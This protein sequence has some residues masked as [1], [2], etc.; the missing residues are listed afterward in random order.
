MLPRRRVSENADIF[1]YFTPPNGKDENQIHMDH[2][3]K[4][5]T[6]QET[7]QLSKYC[8]FDNHS[9]TIEFSKNL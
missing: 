6:Y 8:W 7:R 9:L 4:E 3:R 5:K 1:R 2:A